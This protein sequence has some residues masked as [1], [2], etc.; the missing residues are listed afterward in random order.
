[1]CIP[2]FPVFVCTLY[3]TAE[4]FLHGSSV[5]VSL[6]KLSSWSPLWESLAVKLILLSHTPVSVPHLSAQPWGP[7]CSPCTPGF[8]SF[9]SPTP[10]LLWLAAPI[11]TE[12]DKSKE[13]ERGRKK[14][15]GGRKG[16][17]IGKGW[18]ERMRSVSSPQPIIRV[19]V[20][21]STSPYIPL[22]VQLQTK[23]ELILTFFLCTRS[24]V[25]SLNPSPLSSVRPASRPADCLLVCLCSLPL[26]S[27]ATGRVGYMKA[28]SSPLISAWQRGWSWLRFRYTTDPHSL[29]S[30]QCQ[31]TLHTSPTSPNACPLY[32]SA[33]TL[34]NL[35]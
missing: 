32:G 22:L 11:E 6:R 25:I 18:R 12:L 14:R 4:S 23:R 21:A 31:H 15:W 24:H 13:G 8:T 7:S 29:A 17:Q 3:N 35:A 16:A 1:M 19:L 20:D 33:L 30:A 26:H 9:F 2:V 27:H 5:C 34:L 10:R 28:S